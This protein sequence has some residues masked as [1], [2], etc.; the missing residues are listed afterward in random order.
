MEQRVI[1]FVFCS[2]AVYFFHV[3]MPFNPGGVLRSAMSSECWGDAQLA[4]LGWNR[5]MAELNLHAAG[6]AAVSLGY[7]EI[8]DVCQT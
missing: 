4:R 8:S 3:E 7:L 2:A 1:G 6:P 5:D